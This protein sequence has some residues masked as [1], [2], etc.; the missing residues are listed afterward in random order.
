MAIKDNSETKER[1][2][3]AKKLD[4]NKFKFSKA[5]FAIKDKDQTQQTNE[6]LTFANT[7]KPLRCRNGLVVLANDN[8]SAVPRVHG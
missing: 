1:F 6:V 4:R 2:N 5:N 7:T 3:N 8:K